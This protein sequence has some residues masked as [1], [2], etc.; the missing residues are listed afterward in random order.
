MEVVKGYEV[1]TYSC[2]RDPQVEYQYF[3]SQDTAQKFF[4]DQ[5]KT[6]SLTNR[7]MNSIILLKIDGIYYPL[8]K[9]VQVNE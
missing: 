5:F 4:D 7:Y 2:M 1:M 6:T 9:P 8:P 3:I